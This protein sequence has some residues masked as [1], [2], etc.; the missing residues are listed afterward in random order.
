MESSKECSQIELHQSSR[1][2]LPP[3]SQWLEMGGI[4]MKT[5]QVIFATAFLLATSVH[6]QAWKDCVR[7]S[8]GPGGCESMGPGGGMSMGPGGGQSMG[9]GG[10]QSMG[11][12]GGQSMGPGGNAP[13]LS[14]P[15]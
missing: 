14:D 6:A 5:K 1:W 15:W 10:G 8:M 11:P 12:G 3:L 13:N 4:N 2:K 9:P 7:N